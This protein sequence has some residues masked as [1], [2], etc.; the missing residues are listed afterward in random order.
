MAPL[1]LTN[2]IF[3]GI[4]FCPINPPWRLP[5]WL[6]MP[7]LLGPMMRKFESPTAFRSK[8]SNESFCMTFRL[9]TADKITAPPQFART[10][11]STIFGTDSMGDVTMA[12]STGSRNF[13]TDETQ[14]RPKRVLAVGWTATTSPWKPDRWRLEKIT[15]PVPCSSSFPPMTAIDDGEKTRSRFSIPIVVSCHGKRHGLIRINH[16]NRHR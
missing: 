4:V 2:A 11:S 6:I 12:R 15:E 13:F 3:P 9:P 7:R 16:Q 10:H 8:A 1:W 5:E 14:R